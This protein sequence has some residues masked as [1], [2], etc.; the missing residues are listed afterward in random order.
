MY[1]YIYIYHYVCVMQDVESASSPIH[2]PSR[3][4]DPRWLPPTNTGCQ[5]HPVSRDRVA[6]GN[7][8]NMGAWTGKII[9]M[10]EYEVGKYMHI[11]I[12]IYI[13]HN[14]YIYIHGIWK[15]RNYDQLSKFEDLRGLFH[16]K[17]PIACG[18]INPI[19]SFTHSSSGRGTG[20]LNRAGTAAKRY[21]G[22]SQAA[23]CHEWWYGLILGKI[24]TGKTWKN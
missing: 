24:D 22:R 15:H 14:I 23:A 13:L 8:Q 4:H 21:L 1:I 2:I 11:Y 7:P 6:M 19:N 16:G 20:H 5:I 10:N 12:Y 9:S 17:S 18:K 3:I